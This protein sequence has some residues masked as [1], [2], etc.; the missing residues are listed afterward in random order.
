LVDGNLA[1]QV[2]LVRRLVELGR[3]ARAESKVRNRQPLGRALVAAPGWDELP[4]EL[5]RQ[6]ADELNV[7]GFGE[8]AGELVDRSAKG[9]FRALGKR[10]GKDTPTVAAAIAAA[11]AAELAA[12]LRAGATATVVVDGADVEVTAEEVLLT[13]TPREGWAVASEA[14]ETVAL[15][16][17]LTPELRRAG[18][19]REVVRLVQDARK[20]AGL[21]VT[22]RVRLRWA[23]EGELADALREHAEQVA[24]EVLATD[25][26]EGLDVPD[27]PQEGVVSDPGLGLRF[28]ITRTAQ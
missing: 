5:R 3:S 17:E 18:L 23:A 14:G 20:S 12:A 6:V 21:Q 15:D 24:A 13:E 10:F 9:N 16:L 19:A 26:A 1:G 11:D 25:F 4:E 27:G 2:A 28:T 22:D 7:V 8:L